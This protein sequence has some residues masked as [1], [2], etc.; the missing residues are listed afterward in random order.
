MKYNAE[1]QIYSFIFN[2]IKLTEWLICI[3]YMYNLASEIQIPA[4]PLTF[5]GREKPLCDPEL[6]FNMPVVCGDLQVAMI[7]YNG[8][9]SY[10]HNNYGAS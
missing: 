10:T 6:K 3:M 1:L 4:S 8:T 9:L 2:H 5:C 7:D